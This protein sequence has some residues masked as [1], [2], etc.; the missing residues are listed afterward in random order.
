M[1][2]GTIKRLLILSAALL[3][4][5]KDAKFNAAADAS[6]NSEMPPNIQSYFTH[7]LP[8]PSRTRCGPAL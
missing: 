3:K 7:D 2:V 8:T 5:I 1:P 6:L 4:E